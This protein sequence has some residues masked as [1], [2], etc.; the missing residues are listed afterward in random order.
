[1]KIGYRP[2]ID[3]LRSI[4]VGTVLLYH[5]DVHVF[6]IRVFQGGFLGVDIF[7]VISGFLITSLIHAEYAGTGRFSLLDFYERRARRLLPAL[8]AVLGISYVV[9]FNVLV[10]TAMEE[11]ARSALASIAFVSNIF[12]WGESTVYGARSGLV[13]PLL[14]TWSLAV[15]EQFYLVF[16]LIYISVLARVRRG[17]GWIG[18]GSVGVGFLLAHLLT[19]VDFAFSFFMIFSRIWELLAG[20]VLAHVLATRPDIGQRIPF[21]GALPGL[22]LL[23]IGYSLV[24]VPLSWHHPGVGTLGAVVGTVLIIGFARQGEPVTWLLSIRPLVG[25]GLISYSLYLWHYPVYA[26]GR[27]RALMEP[28][29]VDYIAWVCLSFAAAI[30]TYYLVEQPFRDRARITR[31]VLTGALTAATLT[32]GAVSIVLLQRDGA[33]GRLEDLTELYGPAEPDNVFLEEVSWSI[34]ASLAE[35]QGY[36]PSTAHEP[37]EFEREVLWFD[38][39][40]AT[41]KLLIIGNSH[42]KD[43]FNALHLNREIFPEFEFARFGMRN[44]IEEDQIETLLAAPNFMH[45]DTVILSFRYH[46]NTMDPVGPLIERLLTAG[47]QVVLTTNTTEF[48]AS[49]VYS[50]ADR[51][52]LRTGTMDVDAINATAW[53]SRVL[54]NGSPSND[55][56]RDLAATYD[57]AILEKEDFICDA[58]R[59]TCANVTLSGRKAIYDYGHYTLDG[60]ILFGRRI[61]ELGWLDPLRTRNEPGQNDTRSPIPQMQ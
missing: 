27:L 52:L 42:G 38:P 13:Q 8:F 2:E 46:M 3:G 49:E 31:P 21:A 5:L 36:A 60:A 33:P 44:T 29:M 10:P 12:W 48:G 30:L 19:R 24:A 23:M 37:S 7:F 28:G 9:A 53:K 1:M 26:F 51:H 43:L 4:A 22:G 40:A 15:E 47:K 34:L 17:L 16:P 35:Q 56:L 39:G 57:L 14:H 41:Q 61:A 50:I 58:T 55:V 45:A 54:S 32:I 11:F 6:G 18:F 59:R 20:A 25:M